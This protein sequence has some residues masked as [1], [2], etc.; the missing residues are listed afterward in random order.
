MNNTVVVLVFWILAQTLHCFPK[1]S[2]THLTNEGT[3][4]TLRPFLNNCKVIWYVYFAFEYYLYFR[5]N[6]HNRPSLHAKSHKFA[7]VRNITTFATMLHFP[8]KSYRWIA[9]LFLVK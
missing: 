5:V 7:R 3:V 2:T 6:R 1:M 8:P 9:R 4:L